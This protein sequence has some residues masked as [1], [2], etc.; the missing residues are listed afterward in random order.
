MFVM[1]STTARSTSG[2]FTISERHARPYLSSQP[3]AFAQNFPSPPSSRMTVFMSFLSK[4]SGLAAAYR[5]SK[6]P[7]RLAA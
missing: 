6:T 1:A 4:I 7:H 5:R 3:A 2:P